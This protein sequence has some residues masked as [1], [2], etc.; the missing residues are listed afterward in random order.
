M[1]PRE[2][3]FLLLSS[4]LGD[5]DRKPLSRFQLRTLAERVSGMDLPVEDR[6]LALSDLI[7]LGYSRDM[8]ARILTLLGQTEELAYYLSRG[9]GAGCVPITRVSTGYPAALRQRLGLDSPGCLWAKG[10]LRL[11]TKPAVA[12]VGSRDLM[13]ENRL[14][15]RAVG[16]MAAKNGFILVSGNARGA[17]RAAQDACLASGGRVISVLADKLTDHEERENLLYLSEDGY[18]EPFSAQRALSRNRCIHAL[19]Q[20][21]FVAQSELGKGGTWDGTV[22]NLRRGWSTVVC[23]RDGSPASLEM[24]HLGAYLIGMEEMK[25]FSFTVMTEKSL[26][27]E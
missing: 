4:H 14:F 19:S 22:K 25:D 6:E 21:T 10:D 16:E 18:A 3:G 13:E 11:L 17:D 15:A 27:E 23:F 20:L 9:K 1:N 8:A 24:E 26:F 12:L 2:K 7:A 5:P